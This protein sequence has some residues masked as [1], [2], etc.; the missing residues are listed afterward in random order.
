MTA[1]AYRCQE[2]GRTVSTRILHR[3]TGRW[4][5]VICADDLDTSPCALPDGRGPVVLFWC[6]VAFVVLVIAGL[7]IRGR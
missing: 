3:P 4:H 1:P 7:L 5:C 2:C 6:C